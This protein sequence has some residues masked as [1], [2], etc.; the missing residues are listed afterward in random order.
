MDTSQ[1]DALLQTLRDGLDLPEA[2]YSKSPVRLS[3]GYD[4]QIYEFQLSGVPERL[5]GLLVFRI[6]PQ[7]ND[8]HRALSE[9]AIQ[10][11][12]VSTGL[13]VPKVHFT[14]SESSGDFQPFLVMDHL[15]GDTL[16]Q[17]TEPESSLLLGKTHAELHQHPIS[18]VIAGLNNR[19]VQSVLLAD[20]LDRLTGAAQGFSWA[21]VVVTWLVQHAPRES[22]RS[23]CHGDFHKLNVL[24]KAGAVTGILDWSNFCVAEAAFDVANTIISFSILAKHL[25]AQGDFEVVDLDQVLAQYHKAYETERELDDTNLTYYLVLRS[26][27]ILFL[28]A[29][30]MAKPYRHPMVVVDLCQLIERHSGIQ[31]SPAVIQV[32]DNL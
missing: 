11:T 26:T 13:L 17:L 28:A 18:P 27:M 10:N 3:G 23:I 20:L 15:E 30:G 12:L 22:S 9:A 6:F 21:N 24:Q 14:G 19:G 25:T 7:R 16:L 31:I 1:S 32:Q 8:Q 29:L 4:T 2:G 5:S